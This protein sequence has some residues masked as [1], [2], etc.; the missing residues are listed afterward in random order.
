[1]VVE[2]SIKTNKTVIKSS[3]QS[4]NDKSQNLMYIPNIRT[5]RK[6]HFLTFNTKKIFNY[7]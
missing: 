7:L 5:T 1:M 3:Y 6:S 4:K 2:V